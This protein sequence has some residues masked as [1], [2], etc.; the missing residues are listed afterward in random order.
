[1]EKFNF[2]PRDGYEN[3]SDFPN[4]QSESETREQ[5]QR[6][7]TQ[8]RDFI[9]G[10]VDILS[11]KDGA[12]EIGVNQIE[13]LVIN[14]KI[15]GNVGEQL[16]ALAE[17]KAYAEGFKYLRITEDKAIEFSEDGK[18]WT[19]TASSGHLIINESGALMPQR[20]KLK[21]YDTVLTDEDDATCI[22]GIIGPQGEQGLQGVE[23]PMGPEGPQGIPGATG[24]QGIQGEQGPQGV[25][26][27]QGPQGEQGEKGATGEQGPI[28]QTGATGPQGPKGDPGPQGPQG[29]QGPPGTSA[30]IA[31]TSGYFA[32]EIDDDGNLYA[33]YTDDTE[34]PSFEYEEDTGNLYM[35]I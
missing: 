25:Q 29:E 5:I 11:G 30:V 18:V 32:L 35:I 15:A 10:L 23:G 12:K 22:H 28:G 9:N 17:L 8:T 31:P 24:Q 2:T 26:G 7:H 33:T 21:F 3:S 34:T 4:P 14:G 20:T 27:E 13:E 16:E 1:M 19:T 6:L